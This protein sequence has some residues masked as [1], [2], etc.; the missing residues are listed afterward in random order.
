MS[1]R[2]AIENASFWLLIFLYSAEWCAAQPMPSAPDTVR[3]EIKLKVVGHLPKVLRE[4][5]GLERTSSGLF[6]THNDDRFS[7]L[8][9]LDSTGRTIKTVHLNHPNNGWEDLT[10]DKAGNMYIGGFGNNQN[11][12]RNLTIY[13]VPD[14]DSITEQ[15]YTAQRIE[16]TYADQRAYPPPPAEQNF[17]MDAFTCIGDSLYLF[18]KNR[19]Q[20]FSG[21]TKIYT[22]PQRPGA[23]TALLIDSIFLG[24]GPMMHYWITSADVNPGGDILALLSHDCIWIV[25]GFKNNRFSSGKIH[26]ID[27]GG[28]SHKSGLCFISDSE[29]YLVDEL[30]FGFLG[31]NLYYLDL[32]PVLHEILPAAP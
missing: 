26:R 4:A 21:Y 31:G 28:F 12:R 30:E 11:V 13:K 5:S 23:H 3:A 14:P 8:Y 19:T 16:Y 22:L 9:G 1:L 29:L 15:V 18:T 17:D 27:L 6:W 20:P 25:S 10:L 24:K 7:I 2:R 32:L